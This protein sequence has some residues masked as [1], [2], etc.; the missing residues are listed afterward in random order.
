[1]VFA[2][3]ISTNPEEHFQFFWSFKTVEADLDFKQRIF[4]RVVRNLFY[5][6][7]EKNL[8]QNNIFWKKN[9]ENF[10]RQRANNYRDMKR[11]IS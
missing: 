10:F 2:K 3:L 5:V 8:L 11:K 6:S 7:G 9:F 4:G 1:M